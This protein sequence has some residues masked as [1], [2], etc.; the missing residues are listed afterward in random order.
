MVVCVGTVRSSRTTARAKGG[1]WGR[2]RTRDAIVIIPTGVSMIQVITIGMRGDIMFRR[3]VI[4][5]EILV[6]AEG[7]SSGR[8][9]WTFREA[10]RAC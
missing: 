8:K 4:T 5:G 3:K 7:G 1:G 9:M 6:R 2:K 10:S